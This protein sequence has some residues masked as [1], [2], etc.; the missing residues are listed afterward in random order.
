VNVSDSAA[1]IPANAFLF[2]GL[3]HG[4]VSIDGVNGWG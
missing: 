3:C 4:K 1:D 2:V